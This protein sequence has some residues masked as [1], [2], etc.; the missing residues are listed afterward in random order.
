[1]MK[2]AAW[3]LAIAS[4]I[5]LLLSSEKRL[6]GCLT[7]FEPGRMCSLCSASS[8]GTP[9]MSCGDHA[10][11]SRFSRRNSTSSLSYLLLSPAPTTTNL[12]ESEGSRATFLLSLAD[13]KIDSSFSLFAGPT[14]RGDLALCLCH[15]DHLAELALLLCDHVGIGQIAASRRA[16]EGLP[17]V[18]DD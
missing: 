12:V 5:A 7:G 16:F 17:E 13:W 11:M 15:C 18:P 10:K 1:M 8:L 14:G 6:K 9:G 4:P 3:S 2:P